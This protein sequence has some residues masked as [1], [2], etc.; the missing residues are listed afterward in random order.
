MPILPFAKPTFP[1]EEQ[2]VWKTQILVSADGS[3]Q[4]LALRKIPRQ[5]LTYTYPLKNDAEVARMD[6]ILHYNAQ[7]LWYVPLWGEQSYHA[8]DLGAGATSISFDTTGAAYHAVEG[9]TVAI[10]QAGQ[11]EVVAVSAVTSTA[12]TTAALANGYRGNKVIAPCRT[13]YLL[14]GATKQRYRGGAALLTLSFELID[15]FFISGHSVAASYEGTEVLTTPARMPGGRYS[16][17]IDPNVIVLDSDTG[18]RTVAAVADFAVNAQSHQFVCDGKATVWDLRQWLHHIAGRQKSFL[19]PTFRDDLLLSQACGAGDTTID[20]AHR[21]FDDYMGANA[22]RRYLAFRPSGSDPVVRRVTGITELSAT[23]ERVAINASPGAAYAIGAGLSWV[24]QC[25]L[26][27]DTVA[28]HWIRPGVAT[29]D[30]QL[31][32]VAKKSSANSPSASVSASPSASISASVSSSPSQSIST[33]PS[34]SPSA[35]SS[36]SPS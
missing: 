14:A 35:S 17:R 24:D 28:L 15:N 30:T 18:R 36:S 19:V 20:V 27:S 12:L 34:A 3:E 23:E 4:R 1:F 32:R 22:L 33:S 16:Q 25:R 31:V 2:L 8:A 9:N 29:V 7:Q 6:A 11:S 21:G 5:R 13:G 26:A 10:W